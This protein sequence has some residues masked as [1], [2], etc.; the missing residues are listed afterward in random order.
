M[1]GIAEG[2]QSNCNA[3]SYQFGP[4]LS[5]SGDFPPS[6]PATDVATCNIQG[7]IQSLA[8][9]WTFSA[10]PGDSIVLI[11]S[12]HNYGGLGPPQ[13]IQLACQL[14]P[15]AN[16]FVFP[17]PDAARAL[18]QPFTDVAVLSLTTVVYKLLP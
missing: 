5:V 1:D 3:A 17:Q 6:R 13:T 4:G 15:P 16:S 11:V 14:F 18:G 2:L 12:S 8:E 7:P 10:A 9:S